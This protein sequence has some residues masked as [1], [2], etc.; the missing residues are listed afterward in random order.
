MGIDLAVTRQRETAGRHGME[1]KVEGSPLTSLA[2]R[3][4]SIYRQ[5]FVM[6]F[7]EGWES[8]MTADYI[9]GCS[10]FS[11]S[12]TSF[13]MALY[14]ADEWPATWPSR[15]IDVA[16]RAWITTFPHEREQWRILCI[17]DEVVGEHREKM[18]E[19]CTVGTYVKDHELS[20]VLCRM[21]LY[22]AWLV[23]TAPAESS[24]L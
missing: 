1:E 23:A 21:F 10:V 8:W 6:A 17:A 2:Q 16:W 18:D 12:V 7:G 5:A 11:H 14:V 19:Q 20:I 15:S 22:Q 9:K 3:R 24:L 4:R 13:I